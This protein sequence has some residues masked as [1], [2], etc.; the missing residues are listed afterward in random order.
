MQTQT[1]AC[2]TTMVSFNVI[3]GSRTMT[4]IVRPT[5]FTTPSTE[6]DVELNNVQMCSLVLSLL[7]ILFI[8]NHS[9]L[10]VAYVL[11][12]FMSVCRIRST[13]GVIACRQ[14][15]HDSVSTVQSR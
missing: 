2:K 10:A 7:G 1:H 13:R 5:L 15:D 11:N 4:E 14:A 3:L 9:C 6:R 8:Y 12:L